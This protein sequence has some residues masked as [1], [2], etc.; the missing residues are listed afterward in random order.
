MFELQRI[1]QQNQIS[2]LRKLLSLE[3]FLRLRIIKN[4]RLRDSINV[5]LHPV[6]E[7]QSKHQFWVFS[8]NDIAITVVMIDIRIGQNLPNRFRIEMCG[9]VGFCIIWYDFHWK[10]ARRLEHEMRIKMTWTHKLVWTWWK[11]ERC[12]C[13]KS[14]SM[15]LME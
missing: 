2:E 8:C 5:D 6:G 1:Q 13:L 4:W 9:F 14:N 3:L 10:S 12:H 11:C 15:R 7:S